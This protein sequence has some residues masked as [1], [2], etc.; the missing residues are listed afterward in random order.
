[1]EG[2]AR[3]VSPIPPCGTLCWWRWIPRLHPLRSTHNAINTRSLFISASAPQSTTAV[4]KSCCD[5]G[6]PCMG[7]AAHVYKHSVGA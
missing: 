4:G 7:C 3:H 2:P 1:M 5:G 6:M